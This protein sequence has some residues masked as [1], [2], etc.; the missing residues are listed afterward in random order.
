[1]DIQD[2]GAFRLA[3]RGVE[4]ACLETPAETQHIHD[5]DLDT[6]AWTRR[7]EGWEISL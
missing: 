1:M 2:G 4:A 5:A 6:H 3:E 7:M